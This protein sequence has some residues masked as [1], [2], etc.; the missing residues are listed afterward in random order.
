MALKNC[1][2]AVLLDLRMDDTGRHHRLCEDGLGFLRQFRAHDEQQTILVRY[3]RRYRSRTS[4]ILRPSAS[5]VN[6]LCRN[7]IPGLSTPWW[8]IVSSVYP[9][10]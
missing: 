8:T 9:D 7:A 3:S 2:S 5:E 6:G 4:R 1:P 10:M